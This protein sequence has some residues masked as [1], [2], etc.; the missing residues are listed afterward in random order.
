MSNDDSSKYRV[1]KYQRN[2]ESVMKSLL[3]TENIDEDE[4]LKDAYN[5]LTSIK[6]ETTLQMLVRVLEAIYLYNFSEE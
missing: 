2:I 1:E 3:I 4:F 5:F 6:D